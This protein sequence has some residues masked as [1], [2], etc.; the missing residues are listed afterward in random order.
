MFLC[1]KSNF[2]C[3]CPNMVIRPY[4]PQKYLKFKNKVFIEQ[5]ISIRNQKG[6]TTI[7]KHF[8]QIE[9]LWVSDNEIPENQVIEANIKKVSKIKSYN[10]ASSIS[11]KPGI[12]MRDNSCVCNICLRG[13][14][15]N[16]KER[17]S[18]GYKLFFLEK[19]GKESS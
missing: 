2:E 17:K 9:M 14:N 6:S 11:G 1:L 5:F 15:R 4:S 13:D 10:L 12:Y 7:S 3:I 8:K 16:C 19:K 18:G